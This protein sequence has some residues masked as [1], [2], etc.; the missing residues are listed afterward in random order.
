MTHRLPASLSAFAAALSASLCIQ[1]AAAVT[2]TFDDLNDTSAGFGGTPI[3]N[4]YQGLNWT[5]WNVLDSFDSESV[6]GPNGAVAGTVSIPN[7]A[8]NP[9]G[10][11]AIFSS[12]TPFAFDSAYL[13]AVWNQGL[14]VTITGLLNGTQED[15]TVLTNLSPIA[16]TLETFDWSG[17]NEVD[18]LATGGT[19]Y[20]AYS[21]SGTQ[22]AMDNLTITPVPE[23]VSALLFG[24]GLFGL[25]FVW[26]RRRSA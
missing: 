16:P 8:Y 22:V 13:T 20:S 18:L 21:G 25:A 23:P 10:G 15:Q 14:S 12:A 2:I 4:G 6:F 1:P 26:H 5:N 19:P 24:S 9:D 17:I 3:A 7:L 11:E